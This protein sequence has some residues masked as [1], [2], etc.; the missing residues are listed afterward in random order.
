MR[1]LAI[2]AECRILIALHSAS[3]VFETGVITITLLNLV[4][5]LRTDEQLTAESKNDISIM[6]C[7]LAI[8]LGKYVLTLLGGGDSIAGL[9]VCFW[10]PAVHNTSEK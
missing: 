9:Q 7:S 8:S 10:I 3:F 5:H 4:H 2:L 1:N 6:S